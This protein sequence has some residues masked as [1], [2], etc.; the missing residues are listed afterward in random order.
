MT[1]IYVNLIREFG[2]IIFHSVCENNKLYMQ[3]YIGTMG[4]TTLKY[5]LKI[6]IVN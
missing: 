2:K 1:K 4:L 5:A 6:S 3:P